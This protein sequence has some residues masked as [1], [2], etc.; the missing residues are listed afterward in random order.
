MRTPRV[1]TRTGASLL[2]YTV[3]MAFALFEQF[4]RTTNDTKTPLIE[5]PGSF[6]SGALTLWDPQTNF[7]ELQN[8]A[9]GYLFPQGPFF[10]VSHLVHLPPWIAERFW[11]VLLIV[12]GAEGARLLARSMG[13]GA[14]PAWVAGMAYGLNP[15]VVGQV[16]VR[17]AEILPTA[18]LPWV[19]L[20]VVLALT[21]RLDPRRAAL[22]SAVA[23]MFS[24]AVNGT[25]TAAGLPFVVVLIVWGVRRGLVGRSMLGW[26]LLL[27]TLVS[28]WWASSLQRLN[29][30]SPPFIDFVEDARATTETTGYTSALR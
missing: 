25:A 29:A 14:W 13:L 2:I 7:G 23:F 20:P 21:G 19:A 28:F 12:V 6:L 5:N 18:V 1:D 15:R 11:S 17:S 10:L 16:A 8:Q 9:Y 26:W 27:V 24:G 4:G 22:F 30:Y 3:L